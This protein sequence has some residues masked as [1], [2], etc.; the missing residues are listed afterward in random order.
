MASKR[1]IIDELLK[2]APPGQV[3]QVLKGKK[4]PY[5]L[6]SDSKSKHLSK[7][8]RKKKKRERKFSKVSSRTKTFIPLLNLSFFLL[9][10]FPDVKTLVGDDKLV[11]EV[12]SATIKKYDLDNLTQVNYDVDGKACEV[13]SK[14]KQ[15]TI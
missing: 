4:D 15:K 12:A 8:E 1:K 5:P 14:Q 2:D 3:K 10:H 7:T 11:D 6:R 9:H 13:W